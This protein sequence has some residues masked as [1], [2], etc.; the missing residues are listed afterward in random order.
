ME[1]ET[2]NVRALLDGY[3]H[4]TGFVDVHSYSEVVLYPWGDDENQSTNPTKNFLNPAWDDLRGI[5][6]DAYREYIPA[7]DHTKFMAMGNKIRDAI[8]AVRDRTYT[9][10]QVFDPPCSQAQGWHLTTPG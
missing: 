8:A 10:Q 6:G 4:I 3:P 1:P 2:R 5:L 9:V 7:A